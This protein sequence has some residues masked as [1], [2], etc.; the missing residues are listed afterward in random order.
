MS[1]PNLPLLRDSSSQR[2]SGLAPARATNGMLKVRRLYS[3]E[4]MSFSLAHWPLTRVQRD[5]LEAVYQANKNGNVTLLWPEDGASY[6]VRFA[7]APQHRL[8]NGYWRS[9][10]RLEEV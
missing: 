1:Y 6:T 7:A 10:V 5:Q 8:E 4:K 2:E 9:T 3:T